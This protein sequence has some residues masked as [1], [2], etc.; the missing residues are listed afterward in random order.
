M[1]LKRTT[2]MNQALEDAIAKFD[3][4]ADMARQMGVT[5]QAIKDWRKRGRV[6]AD[7]CIKLAELTGISRE[8]LVGWPPE[9]TTERA[10]ASDDVQPPVGGSVS[11]KR[12]EAQMVA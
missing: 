3:S 8:A 6:P 10:K 5:Y 1:L 9:D 2:A 11:K 12:K 7:R 4:I